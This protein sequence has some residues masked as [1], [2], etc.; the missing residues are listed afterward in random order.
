MLTDYT[1]IDLASELESVHWSSSVSWLVGGG[2]SCGA[3]PGYM[4]DSHCSRTLH[5]SKLNGSLANLSSSSSFICSSICR[6]FS[7]LSASAS[8]ISSTSLWIKSSVSLWSTGVYSSLAFVSF[9][10]EFSLVGLLQTFS[11]DSRLTSGSQT[12]DSQATLLIIFSSFP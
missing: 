10:S 6:T 7:Q 12:S 1:T 11:S 3:G 4:S 8:S 9:D 2:N 5:R